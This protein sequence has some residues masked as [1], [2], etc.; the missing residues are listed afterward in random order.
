[1]V[2]AVWAGRVLLAA[3]CINPLT[4]K[5]GAG[6]SRSPGIP[7]TPWA[8]PPHHQPSPFSRELIVDLAGVRCFLSGKA[9]RPWC[10]CVCS[11]PMWLRDHWHHT[12][13]GGIRR[14][15]SRLM[16]GSVMQTKWRPFAASSACMALGSG[17]CMA[18]G[19]VRWCP[20]F[21]KKTAAFH[22]TKFLVCANESTH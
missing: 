17:K 13:R 5:T 22:K 1:M 18:P 16:C 11:H 19:M 9:V 10:L 4:Q 21:Q 7:K 15:G 12:V 6:P 20:K 14:A 3:R 8:R 2:S